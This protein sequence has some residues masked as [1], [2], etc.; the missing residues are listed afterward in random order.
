MFLVHNENTTDGRYELDGVEAV[1]QLV[2][3]SPGRVRNDLIPHHWAEFGPGDA[4]IKRTISTE[5][6]WH[7]FTGNHRVVIDNPSARVHPQARRLWCTHGQD[8]WSV[9]VC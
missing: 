5:L 9:T 3:L 1:G 2:L 8:R 6:S 4:L 7:A